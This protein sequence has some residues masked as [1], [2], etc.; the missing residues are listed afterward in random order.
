MG[1]KRTAGTGKGNRLEF[2]V[3]GWLKFE[4]CFLTWSI[5][6]VMTCKLCPVTENKRKSMSCAENVMLVDW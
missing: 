2:T 3:C 6:F 1:K 4:G 5:V